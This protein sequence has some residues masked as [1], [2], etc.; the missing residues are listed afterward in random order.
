TINVSILG[1]CFVSVHKRHPLVK[2]SCWTDLTRNSPRN[3]RLA[4]VALNHSQAMSIKA[5]FGFSSTQYREKQESVS[6]YELKKK[7][8]VKV[9]RIVMTTGSAMGARAA[10]PYTF[11]ATLVVYLYLL[12]QKRILERQKVL[13]EELLVDRGEV[14][15]RVRIRDVVAGATVAIVSGPVTALSGVPLMEN[16]VHAVG[17]AGATAIAKHGSK[18]QRASSEA[19]TVVEGDNSVQ[20]EKKDDFNMKLEGINEV[21][22][23]SS[24]PP[25]PPV[26]EIQMQAQSATPDKQP[27]PDQSITVKGD[28]NEAVVEAVSP[29][30][31][32]NQVTVAVVEDTINQKKEDKEDIYRR[33]TEEYRQ[34]V[35]LNIAGKATANHA[36]AAGKLP[37]KH[38]VN[39]AE[40]TTEGWKKE[41]A[42]TEEWNAERNKRGDKNRTQKVIMLD[43][44]KGDKI[45]DD[46]FGENILDSLPELTKA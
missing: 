24:S 37:A 21:D 17:A 3:S 25:L 12:R 5:T 44:S 26:K 2:I 30:D 19:T 42:A 43:P 23:P 11:G 14:K 28:Q 41:R 20:A 1:Y 45:H 46:N 8:H 27:D 10:A 4:L 36:T 18:R 22:I 7:H 34:E 13:I 39:A 31:K 33:K 9:Q 35:Y 16:A 29:L 6:E 15:P 32:E 40:K 38:T